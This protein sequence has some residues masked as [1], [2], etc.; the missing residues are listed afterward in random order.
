MARKY[1]CKEVGCCKVYTTKPNLLRHV[2]MIHHMSGNL[3]TRIGT[4]SR[5]ETKASSRELVVGFEDN[6]FECQFPGCCKCYQFRS[7]LRTHMRKHKLLS[8]LDTTLSLPDSYLFNI[9]DVPIPTKGLENVDLPKLSPSR[10]LNGST[11]P[12]FSLA[13]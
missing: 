2:R 9:G 3:A 8:L 5:G 11:L 6:E 13:N 12:A 10:R 4:A 1:K 7:R